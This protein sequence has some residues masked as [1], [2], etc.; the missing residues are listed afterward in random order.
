M[1]RAIADGQRYG[2]AGAVIATHLAE[3]PYEVNELEACEAL[4]NDYM[5]IVVETGLPDHLIVLHRIAAR[6]HLRHGRLDAGQRIL[7]QLNEIGAQRG[8]RR[9]GAAAW[10]E[11][12]YAALSSNN[13]DDARRSL[14]LGG[15]ATV[16]PG[17][18]DFRLHASDI[19]DLLIGELRLQL[20]LGQVDQAL[21]QL[22]TALQAAEATGRRRRAIRLHFLRAQMLHILRRPREASTAFDTAVTR[23]A[24]GGMIRTL[25]DDGWATEPLINRAA[26]AGNPRVAA[27]LRELTPDAKIS[28]SKQTFASDTSDVTFHLTNREIQVLRLLWKGGSNK[29]I[30]RDLFLTE[31]TIETHLRRI[32]EKLGTRNRTQAAALAREAGAI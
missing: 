8:I 11:R 24:R 25:V 26:V 18:G 15:E 16:W 23:A 13:I 5:P 1:K 32:Y 9:L 30:A 7:A 31:N 19:E 3:V 17:F 29:A 21:P 14:A 6:L 10:L 2:S 20:V 4:V 28:K 22:Q 12:T 27:L